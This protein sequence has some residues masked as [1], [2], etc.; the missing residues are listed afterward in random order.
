MGQFALSF[1]TSL[2]EGNNHA[3]K[4]NCIHF[5]STLMSN[6]LASDLFFCLLDFDVELVRYG[7]NSIIK[8]NVFLERFIKSVS[9]N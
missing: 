4:V 3:G 7:N 1:H 9:R 6:L 2:L 5:A 8:I